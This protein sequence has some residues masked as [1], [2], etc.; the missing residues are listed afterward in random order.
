MCLCVCEMEE[1]NFGGNIEVI[2]VDN[3]E[4]LLASV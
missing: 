3:I 1:I 2:C 4:A